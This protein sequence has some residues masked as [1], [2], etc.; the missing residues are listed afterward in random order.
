MPYIKPL[1]RTFVDKH[2]QTICGY[3]NAWKHQDV[4]RLSKIVS[5][6]LVCV[7]Q[8]R[9]P[10]INRTWHIPEESIVALNLVNAVLDN[11]ETPE[12]RAGV[13]NYCVTRIM[14]LTIMREGVRYHRIQTVEE[15]LDRVKDA[16]YHGW[17]KGVIGCARHEFQ[18]RVS[19]PYEDQKIKEGNGD[20]Y[21]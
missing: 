18:R 12:E 9:P 16:V 3:V 14:V 5:N 19:D 21:K 10:R 4:D 13:L 8:E 15:A 17:L 1:D 20:V 7:Y 2:I 11:F 6:F